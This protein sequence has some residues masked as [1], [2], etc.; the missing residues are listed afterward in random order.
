MGK[1]YYRVGKCT[2]FLNNFKRN[3]FG[4]I[5]VFSK[6]MFVSFHNIVIFLEKLV[7]NNLNLFNLYDYVG[8]F[9]SFLKLF[10]FREN[11]VFGLVE[12]LIKFFDNIFKW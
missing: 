11:Y 10:H 12:L 3:I 6:I 5:L 1:K 4:N 7:Q 2:P 8:N 9:K